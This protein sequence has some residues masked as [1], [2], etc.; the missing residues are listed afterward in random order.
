MSA[1]EKQQPP[2][3]PTAQQGQQPYFPPPPPGPPPGA[4]PVQTAQPVQPPKHSNEVPLP[5]YDIPTY[6]PAHP[7]YAP[8]PGAA[9]DDDIYN[10]SPIDAHPPKW[11]FHAQ[12]SGD[13]GE[14]GK[15]KHRLSGLGAA[16]TSKV[17][18]PVNAL[19]NKLGSEGF[20]PESL[21]KEC[22]KAARILRGFCSTPSPTSRSQKK[23][24]NHSLSVQ[25]TASTATPCHPPPTRPLSLPPAKPPPPN[26]HPP[27]PL[28]PSRNP[29]SS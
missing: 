15:K 8:P 21:D 23:H 9:A 22:E 18:G 27:P 5:D 28:S 12:E 25:R 19:A 1:N 16:F 24:A 3:P 2:A 13:D 11:G 6:N 17:A 10:A 14:G 4:A 7:Q 29:A 20:L 26:H